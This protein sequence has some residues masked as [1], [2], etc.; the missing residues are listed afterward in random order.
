MGTQAL[1]VR[2]IEGYLAEAGWEISNKHTTVSVWH[3]RDDANA[4]IILPTSTRLKDYRQRVMEVVGQI[5]D[6]EVE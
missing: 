3:R 4:E 2:Y 5:I 1:F 6:S